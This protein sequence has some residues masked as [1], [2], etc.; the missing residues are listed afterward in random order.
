MSAIAFQSSSYA[1]GTYTAGTV[2][3]GKPS[4]LA[5]GDYM[6][7]FVSS[8]LTDAATPTI[9]PPSL[10]T[11]IQS[12]VITIDAPNGKIAF[13]L[14]EK[15]ADAG[16]VSG[17][18]FTFTSNASITGVQGA[19]ARFTTVDTVLAVNASADGGASSTSTGSVSISGI[20]PA[21][22]SLLLMFVG[23]GNASSATV[24]TTSAYAMATSNPSWTEAYDTGTAMNGNGIS[25]AMAYGSR[26]ETTA[27]GNAS[28]SFNV[29]VEGTYA[30]IL[31]LSPEVQRP[32]SLTA[33]AT[34]PEPIIPTVLDTVLSVAS[35]VLAPIIS[36]IAPTWS[37]TSKSA[38]A[39][40]T[41]TDK[42]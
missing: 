14:Y 6:V 24:P 19:I 41:N 32:A 9:T 8:Y 10:W 5:A 1:A 23:S 31:A 3:I 13:N 37:N 7:A 30:C 21:V 33:T 29:T 20:T 40:W 15:F 42:S 2:T 26:P 36:I 22:Q 4:G 11:L 38:T 16:D 18:G 27:T 12:E 39:S 34:L 28:A 17:S 35:T 25:M